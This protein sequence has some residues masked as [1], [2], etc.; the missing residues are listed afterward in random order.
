MEEVNHTDENYVVLLPIQ[1]LTLTKAVKYR[2]KIGCVEFIDR[3][4]LLKNKNRYKIKESYSNFLFKLKSRA[5]KFNDFKTFAFIRSKINDSSKFKVYEKIREAVWILAASQVLYTKMYGYTDFGYNF[6]ENNNIVNTYCFSTESYYWK[7]PWKLTSPIQEFK[8][9]ENWLSFIDGTFYQR[10]LKVANK[11]KLTDWEKDLLKSTMYMGKAVLSKNIWEA[12]TYRY[13]VLD[14]LL[15][16]KGEVGHAKNLVKRIDSLIGW[17]LDKKETKRFVKHLYGLRNGL[18]HKGDYS[19]ITVNDLINLDT[20]VRNVFFNIVN[21][22]RYFKSKDDVIDFAKKLDA[23]KI[24]NKKPIR[25]KA[26]RFYGN[27]SYS[28]KDKERLNQKYQY[29]SF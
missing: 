22:N 9:N 13:I 8:L 24:L 14:I 25:P 10:I 12:Y 15:L 3:E 23:Y 27:F 17:I 19:E 1:N 21:L 2:L 26:L 29:I 4:Y 5:D 28:K 6:N 7:T 18:F 20:I 16:K 11:E